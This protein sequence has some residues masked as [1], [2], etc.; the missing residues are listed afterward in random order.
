MLKCLSSPT[1]G[2]NYSH[3][4]AMIFL[5]TGKIA[6]KQSAVYLKKLRQNLTLLTLPCGGVFMGKSVPF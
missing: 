1:P 4:F 3:V 5:R 2:V 6:L